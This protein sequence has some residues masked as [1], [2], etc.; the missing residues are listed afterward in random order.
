MITEIKDLERK[1][2]KEAKIMKWLLI[3]LWSLMAGDI[4]WLAY[5]IHFLTHLH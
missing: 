5:K 2:E 4:C 1:I 3:V